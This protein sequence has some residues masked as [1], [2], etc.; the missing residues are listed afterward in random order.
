MA[1]AE[2]PISRLPNTATGPV[3]LLAGALDF[4]N[5]TH[6]RLST[7]TFDGTPPEAVRMTRWALEVQLLE[8]ARRGT[9]E[10]PWSAMFAVFKH[11]TV[12][13]QKFAELCLGVQVDTGMLPNSEAILEL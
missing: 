9:P 1:V 3:M 13:Q 10:P 4:E 6:G 5:W 8:V 7:A 11:A 2:G 12:P